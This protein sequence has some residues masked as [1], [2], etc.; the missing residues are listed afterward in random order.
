MSKKVPV[1][2]VPELMKYW[3]HNPDLDPT[4]L[5]QFSTE[6]ATWKCPDCGYEWKSQVFSRNTA[7]IKGCPACNRL[8][9]SEK[10]NALTEYP[11]LQKYYDYDAPNN[12][13][14][15]SLL[16]MSKKK[17]HWHCPDCDY[18][19]EQPLKERVR[20]YKG[21]HRVADC[22]VCAGTS[23]KGVNNKLKA[24]YPLIAN[25]WDDEKNGKS[26]D[27]IKSGSTATYW[28]RCQLNHSYKMAPTDR[29]AD[30]ENGRI[31]CPYCDER[32]IHPGHNSLKALY[33]EL[34]KEWD[35]V[36]N[37]VLVDPDKVAPGTNED[38]WWNCPKGHTYRMRISHRVIFH[39][40]GIT[41][42]PYCKGQNKK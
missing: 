24:D 13:P 19:W 4:E 16:P 38:A 27:G 14:L 25:E 33:P 7:R 30:L 28:W 37:Y 40:R 15:E 12:P 21:I 11:D 39:I 2:D 18:C 29:V 17:V 42:C 3:G 1:S 9:A 5:N 6:V 26:C 36:S 41:A 8:V 31:S 10:Y 34:M 20:R 32:R 22:P 35:E 23:V